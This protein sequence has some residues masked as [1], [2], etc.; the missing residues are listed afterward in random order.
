MQRFS[1]WLNHPRVPDLSS[2]A[3]I[4]RNREGTVALKSIGSAT[5]GSA[6]LRRRAWSIKVASGKSG[7]FL[8]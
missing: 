5:P 1:S 2:A 7:S 4:V 3:T 8:P 6:I